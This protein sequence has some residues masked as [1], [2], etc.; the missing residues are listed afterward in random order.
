MPEKRNII[1][2]PD[3]SDLQT[4]FFNPKLKLDLEFLTQKRGPAQ[5]G[6]LKINQKIKLGITQLQLEEGSGDCFN[7]FGF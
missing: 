3:K 2:G 5:T 7:F 1:N 6:K 4:S